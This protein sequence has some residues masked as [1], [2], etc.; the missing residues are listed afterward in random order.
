MN[1]DEKLEVFARSLKTHFYDYRKEQLR[2]TNDDLL[3]LYIRLKKLNIPIP[4]KIRQAKALIKHNIKSDL[5]AL[6]KD[7][8]N[9][10]N[11]IDYFLVG[12]KNKDK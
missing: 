9:V 11:M 8:I 6:N 1:Q 12:K 5:R 4:N 10:L 2:Q 3:L 7:V